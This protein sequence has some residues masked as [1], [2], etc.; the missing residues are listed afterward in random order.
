MDPLIKEGSP[1][2]I[3]TYTG[4]YV[5]PWNLS[6]TD[7]CIEDIATSLSHICRYNGHIEHHYSVAEHSVRVMKLIRDES[8]YPE[9]ALAG[10]LHDASEAYIADL[11]RPVKH[12]DDMGAFR[13]LENRVMTV[14]AKVYGI[15]YPFHHIVKTADD[16]AL[17]HEW[18]Y[19]VTSPTPQIG[20]EQKWAKHEFLFHFRRL[21]P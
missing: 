14:I 7:I 11:T 15:E 10:L 19:F 1:S 6:E 21:K 16:Y 8:S 9:Q 20:W 12:H 5:D 3:R 17:Q 4:K 18:K 13:M 2:S